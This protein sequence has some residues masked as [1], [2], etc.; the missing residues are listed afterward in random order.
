MCC[1][2]ISDPALACLRLHV[3]FL[4]LNIL[5]LLDL[6]HSSRVLSAIPFVY[7][8]SSLWYLLF[9][10]YLLNS[11]LSLLQGGFLS[12]IRLGPL[13]PT[14]HSTPYFYLY[15]SCIC[16]SWFNVFVQL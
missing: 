13:S 5:A 2:I 3:L 9:S 7:S 11:Y 14:F 4:V 15:S 12:Q 8:I 16:N 10:L 1:R 6:F